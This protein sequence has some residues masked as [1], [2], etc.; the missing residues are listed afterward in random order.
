MTIEQNQFTII[1]S[2]A[3]IRGP[4]QKEAYLKKYLPALL[5]GRLGVPRRNMHLDTAIEQV[6]INCHKCS[7]ND[8]ETKCGLTLKI[9]EESPY[10]EAKLEAI[11][12]LD[13]EVEPLLK[14]TQEKGQNSQSIVS[15]LV[16]LSDSNGNKD[17]K[18]AAYNLAAKIG[19]LEENPTH[20]PTFLDSL[21][22]EINNEDYAKKFVATSKYLQEVCG[23]SE[24][25][26]L[27][28]N[29]KGKVETLEPL[30]AVGLIFEVFWNY[31][32]ECLEGIIFE[33]SPFD[34]VSLQEIYSKAPPQH[35][36]EIVQ[37][38]KIRLKSLA[39]HSSS[40]N[41]PATYLAQLALVEYFL[42]KPNQSGIDLP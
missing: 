1:D 2:K 34:L 22:K 10:P 38:I 5:A 42:R 36:A 6:V 17:V 7:S 39:S 4:H 29:A 40:N 8:Y 37:D 26:A 18:L 31:R 16:S 32:Y 25:D 21:S 12:I 3:S 33:K 23:H 28:G 19:G 41:R 20:F 9:V 27:L 11:R 15:K 13:E 30:E 14:A 35:K 24:I